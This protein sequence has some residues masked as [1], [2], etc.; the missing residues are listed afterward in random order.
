MHHTCL[1]RALSQLVGSN[2]SKHEPLWGSIASAT[3]GMLIWVIFAWYEG[4]ARAWVES[5]SLLAVAV[6]G[7]FHILVQ[8]QQLW[9]FG[10]DKIH[11]P[12]ASCMEHCKDQ[13]LTIKQI[14]CSHTVR[15]QLECSTSLRWHH[16][17]TGTVRKQLECSTNSLGY[18][19]VHEP[20]ARKHRQCKDHLEPDS[21]T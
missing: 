10:Y 4:R 14:H 2:Q 17:W 8:K 3:A 21:H 20:D 15:K 11:E 12:A 7:R 6:W 18:G 16:A 13:Q 19:M 9:M 1:T 5:W